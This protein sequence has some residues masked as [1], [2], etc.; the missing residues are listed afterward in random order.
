MTVTSDRVTATAP[1]AECAVRLTLTPDGAVAGRLD[2]AWWPR[3]HDLL[4]E[5]PSLAAELD[6]RWGRV[7]RITV[8]PAQW[9]VVPHRIQVAGHIVHSGW[10]TE[11]DQHE[12]VVSS[13]PPRRLELLVVPPQTGAAEAER[14]MSAA[15]DPLNTR[16]ASVLLA[17][18]ATAGA[19]GRRSAYGFLPSVCPP[20]AGQGAADRRAD[21]ARTRAAEWR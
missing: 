4:L 12:I 9:P 7:T 5:V 2:G 3:S 1:T 10:F 11:Q 13:F 20:P 19:A 16:T 15:A 14:L 18:V 6:R 8:N 17:D 21:V